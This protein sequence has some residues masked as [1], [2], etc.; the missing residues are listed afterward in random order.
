[1]AGERLRE[2]ISMSGHLTPVPTS[3][4]TP[5]PVRSISRADVIDAAARVITRRGDHRMR[6]AAIAY[7][8]GNAQA[9]MASQWFED[10][11]ALIDECYSRTSQGLSDGLLRAETA[12]GTALDKLAA[13][14]VAAL[15]IRRGRGAFLSFRRGGDLPQ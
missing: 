2:G 1:Q 8:A 15:E 7:E 13:F 4:N 14:L 5:T 6:W 12:P 3:A 10:L 11:S 9:V